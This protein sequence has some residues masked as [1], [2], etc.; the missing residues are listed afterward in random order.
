MEFPVKVER[1]TAKCSHKPDTRFDPL[2]CAA[3][4]SH[5]LC[6][7]PSKCHVK[8]RWAEERQLESSI[9]PKNCGCMRGAAAKELLEAGATAV[10][11][12]EQCLIHEGTAAASD[13]VR[14]TPRFPMEQPSY[15]PPDWLCIPACVSQRVYCSTY[16]HSGRKASLP[17]MDQVT[18][19]TH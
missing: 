10:S 1:C 8:L 11:V 16:Y 14:S 6:S 9:E 4:V 7:T 12:P 15:K 17:C 5:V 2:V 18:C 19:L 3:S 13:I